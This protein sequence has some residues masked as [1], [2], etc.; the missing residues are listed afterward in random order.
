MHFNFVNHFVFPIVTTNI[1]TQSFGQIL[2]IQIFALPEFVE[3]LGLLASIPD[4]T[5]FG[6]AARVASA[7]G[8]HGYL[9]IKSH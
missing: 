6:V 9:A 7:A 4:I 3:R 1:G 2:L 5:H 8:R